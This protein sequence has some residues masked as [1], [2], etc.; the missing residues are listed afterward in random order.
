MRHRVN[1]KNLGRSTSYRRAT[2]KSLVRALLLHERIITTRRR[3]KL[4]QREVEPL[5]S[6]AREGSLNSK[7][8][9]YQYLCDHE[10]VKEL[11]GKIAPLFKERS[12]GFTRVVFLKNRRGDNAKLVILELTEKK[13]EEKPK[14]EKKD[15]SKK[16]RPSK[17]EPKKEPQAEERIEVTEEK[18]VKKQ[19]SAP[20]AEKKIPVKEDKAKKKFLGG[21][22][23][24]F[25]KEKNPQ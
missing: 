21:F 4:V 2:L 1:T 14:K 10:L 16:E 17:E 15:K 19:K 25:R 6:M 11:F 7:R 22:K 23:T 13:K 20:S 9:V 3:A 5:L 8:R 24:L 18:P 12:S